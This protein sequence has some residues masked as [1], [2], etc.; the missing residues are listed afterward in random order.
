MGRKAARSPIPASRPGR[1]RE[2]Q[3]FLQDG[4]NGKIPGRAFTR[5][6]LMGKHFG[7]PFSCSILSGHAPGPQLWPRHGCA[8]STAAVPGPCPSCPAETGEA[9]RAL[10]CVGRDGEFQQDSLIRVPDPARGSGGG[11]D[12]SSD[13]RGRELRAAL[14][15]GSGGCLASARSDFSDLGS[16]EF[17]G[18]CS[19]QGEGRAGKHRLL[20]C[21]AR[22]RLV[23]ALQPAPS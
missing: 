16:Q 12:A 17:G 23:A 22:H 9:G 3:P 14:D 10:G 4:G 2:P 15:T 5:A 6:G 8:R 13:S 7:K 11:M 20:P 1:F 21:R 19:S 18:P